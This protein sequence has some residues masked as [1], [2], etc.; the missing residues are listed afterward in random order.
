M[1]YICVR[2]DHLFDDIQVEV[3]QDPETWRHLT[4]FPDE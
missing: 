1:G 3:T 4:E 2:Q